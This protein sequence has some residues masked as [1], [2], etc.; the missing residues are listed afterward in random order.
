M[1]QNQRIGLME[2]MVQSTW[3]FHETHT[4]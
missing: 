2:K 3:N 1:S 4:F